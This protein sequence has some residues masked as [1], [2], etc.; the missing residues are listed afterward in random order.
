MTKRDNQH[1]RSMH[2]DFVVKIYSFNPK[3]DREQNDHLVYANHIRNE[4]VT[5]ILA[6]L[7]KRRTDNK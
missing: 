7:R 2:A 3:R 4:R 1:K 5:Q 6:E